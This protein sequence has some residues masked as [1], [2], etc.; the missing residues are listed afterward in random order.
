MLPGH[1]QNMTGQ[2]RASIEEG[3]TRWIVE[4]DLGR[5]IAADDGAEDT[6][7]T[8]RAIARLEL[9]VEDHGDRAPLSREWLLAIRRNR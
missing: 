8:A 3:D 4:D 9:D 6:L 1:E 7:A 5:R 2:E